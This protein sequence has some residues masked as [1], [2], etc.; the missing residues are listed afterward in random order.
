MILLYGL[1]ADSPLAMVHAELVRHQQAAVLVDQREILNMEADVVFG[2]E[3]SG[4]LRIGERV[5]DLESV[6]AV[7]LRSY[8]LDQLPPLRELDRKSPQWLHAVSVNDTISAWTE[9]TRALVVN[10]L[11]AMANNGSKPFQARIIEEHGF[12]TPDTL[13]TTDPDAVREFWLQHGT[14]IYKSISGVRSIVNRLTAENADRLADLHW[15]PTQFQQYVPGRDYRVH[16]AGEETFGTEIV[17]EADDYRYAARKG[18]KAT[19]RACELPSDVAQRCVHLA[20]SMELPVA[21][22]D[23][24]YHP[25]GRWFCFEVN[26]SPA[27]SYYQ[28][29]TGQPIA[30]AIT[31]ILTAGNQAK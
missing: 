8:G 16:V 10:R 20:R 18:Q 2:P 22:I 6:T 15:C 7:Y 29:E 30:A 21:G 5:I 9:L 17:S 19:L 13:V 3:V 12:R 24:R 4:A 14:V 23:L 1:P 26:P 28:N 31:R 25:A 27:F 11:S